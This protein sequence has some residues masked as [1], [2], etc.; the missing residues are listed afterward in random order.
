[1]GKLE[2]EVMDWIA[3]NSDDA[4]L[5]EHIQ[6]AT[7]KKRDYMRTGFFIYFDPQPG[8]TAIQA[9]VRPVCP[10]IT[11]AELVDGAGCSLF[12]RN[13]QLH[14]LEIYSRS[15]FIPEKLEEFQLGEAD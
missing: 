8:L 15:G 11:S 1:M 9:S 3:S 4:R 10:H 6:A 13:G 2:Q 7:V 5:S 12:L 14:Y